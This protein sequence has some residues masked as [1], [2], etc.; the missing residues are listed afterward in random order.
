MVKGEELEL[1]GFGQRLGL[2]LWVAARWRQGEKLVRVAQFADQTEPGG[3][4]R[5]RVEL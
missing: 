2:S 4:K 1:E 5:A 3:P